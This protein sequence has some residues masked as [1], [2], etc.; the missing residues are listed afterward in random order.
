[1]STDDRRGWGAVVLLARKG[2]GMT[3][4]QLKDASGVSRPTIRGIEKGTTN[5][6]PEQLNRV[7]AALDLLDDP[8]HPDIAVFLAKLRPLLRQMDAP[9]RAH[10][11][12]AVVALVEQALPLAPVTPIRPKVNEASEMS[13]FERMVAKRSGEAAGASE[14]D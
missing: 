13:E 9:T 3:Q 1:M 6:H 5:P 10:L 2:R 12:P 7:L 4:E 8:A 14:D 11:M